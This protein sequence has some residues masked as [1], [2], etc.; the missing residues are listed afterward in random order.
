MQLKLF[1]RPNAVST[2]APG[3]P[4]PESAW[5]ASSARRG[6]PSASIVAFFAALLLGLSA[7]EPQ[8][9]SSRG[10]GVAPPH[11]AS[12]ARGLPADPGSVEPLWELKLGS[13]QYSIPTVDRGRIY[14]AAND[15][16]F[17]R[18]GFTPTGGGVVLCVDQATG[19]PIWRLPSPR[20][21][22]GVQP[23]YHFDQW[24]CGICSGPV[25][26][27]DRVFVVGS[28][29][30]IL[31]L[32]R[33]GQANGNQGPFLDELTYMG[34]TNTPEA[35]LAPTDGDI[36]WRYNLITQLGVVLHDVCGST[37]L[38][39]GNFLYA[40]TS[41][42]IDDR[43]DKIPRPDAPSLIVLDAQTGRQVA[44]DDVKIGRRMLHCNWSSPVAGGVNGQTRIFFGGADGILYAFQ[45]PSPASNAG[46]QMLTNVWSYDANPPQYR[47]RDGQRIPYSTHSK[48]SPDGPSEIIGTPVFHRGRVYVAIGQSPL[49]GV[50]RGCLSCVD[51]A[52]G[53]PVWVSELVDRTLATAAI[54]DGLLYLPDYSGNL[55]CFDA[56]TGERYWVHPLGAKTWSSSALVADGKVYLGTEAN[57]LWVLQAGKELKVLS[58]ARFRS[59]P[60]TPTAAEGVLYVPTQR[61]LLAL[62]GKPAALRRASA[63]S[64]TPS[65]IP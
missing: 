59:V 7:A 8:I 63:Q 36:L 44:Q 64:N 29:G 2:G 54:A 16:G 51:A 33:E 14:V 40:C 43:H 4:Q 38:L 32:D 1:P 46:L 19:H 11:H 65:V 18:P 53:K 21:F 9:L 30:E 17:E 37:L 22:A 60:I 3:G 49:H 5:L 48:N 25:V 24:N 15:A 13:H 28:R 57:T 26:A 23:P 41:N 34:I 56:D 61:S 20:Y 35:R 62:S 55:H 6:S 45:P 52:S 39:D 47:V 27:G 58:Q 42:G 10:G 50:G 12:S 31:C